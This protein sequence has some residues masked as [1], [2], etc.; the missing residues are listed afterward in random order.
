MTNSVSQS[1]KPSV[2]VITVAIVLAVGVAAFFHYSHLQIGGLVLGKKED[3]TLVLA[4][5]ITTADHA[6]SAGNY[7]QALSAIDGAIKIE[8][9]D[10]RLLHKRGLI[11][12]SMQN[13]DSA[14]ENFSLSLA[15]N[16]LNDQ[17]LLDRASC[18]FATRAYQKA[19]A[20]YQTILT[21]KDSHYRKEAR[22]G[23]ALC[24][25]T[26]GQYGLAIHQCRELVKNFPGYVKAL[27]VL[28]NS[29]LSQASYV[30]AI[31]AYTRGLRL[32]HSNGDLYY[33]RAV[34]YYKN[35]MPEKALSDLKKAV[36]FCPGK[37][38]YHLKLAIVANDLRNKELTKSE[39]QAVL[40]LSPDNKE[41]KM[42][43]A[44]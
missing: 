27:E 13:N 9:N 30:D 17:A 21:L 18:Y 22:L 32:E 8:K 26:L 29:Y 16:A 5:L 35:H 11:Y 25:Y 42:M 10:S 7:K 23:E 43:L 3:K 19:M 37:V 38:D 36:E 34:A 20:D 4:R 44:Q 39:A 31:D 40:K 12:M 14:I 24:H 6:R 15:I 28:A 1:S 2:A 41:A 33:G